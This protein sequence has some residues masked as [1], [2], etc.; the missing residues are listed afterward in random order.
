MILSFTNVPLTLCWVRRR[1]VFFTWLWRR[2]HGEGRNWEEGKEVA[3][4]CASLVTKDG[5]GGVTGMLLQKR[6][7]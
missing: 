6:Q 5:E 2:F 7:G 3:V 1:V 4:I